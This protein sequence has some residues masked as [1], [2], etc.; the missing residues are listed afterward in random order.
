LRR[1]QEEAW[2]SNKSVATEDTARD[3]LGRG[4][5]SFSDG[6]DDATY[7]TSDF[8]NLG[9]YHSKL[10]VHMCTSATCDQ[11]NPIMKHPPGV[12]FV[13]TKGSP[14]LASFAENDNEDIISGSVRGASP[15][16]GDIQ[17][18]EHEQTP[19]QKG[20]FSGFRK[21]TTKSEDPIQRPTSPYE[22]TAI[23]MEI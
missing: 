23:E 19:A 5:N 15:L 1:Q 16:P 22:M 9:L 13:S 4:S 7:R 12:F 21:R 3:A 2:G 8:N 6:D 18:D 20:V 11:C 17:L 10:D 14:P